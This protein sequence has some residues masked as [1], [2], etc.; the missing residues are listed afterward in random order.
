MPLVPRSGRPKRSLKPKRKARP[1]ITD[2]VRV[3]SAGANKLKFIFTVDVLRKLID[4]HMMLYAEHYLIR[5]IDPYT[6][7]R[8]FRIEFARLADLRIPAVFI[9]IEPPTFDPRGKRIHPM[10]SPN[11]YFV[12]IVATKL[13]VR[14]PI[15]PRKLELLWADQGKPGELAGLIMTFP[16][17]DMVFDGPELPV[18]SSGISP[19]DLVA[20]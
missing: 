11:T 6:R 2:Q 16:D 1:P 10:K 8:Q 5:I 4:M 19:R 18:K 14:H 13:K 7:Y 3:Y 15:P 12:E 20:R 17:E 9:R